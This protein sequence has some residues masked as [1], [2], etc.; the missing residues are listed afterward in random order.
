[1]NELN[2]W[3]NAGLTP[4]RTTKATAK[5]AQGIVENVRLTGM[6]LEGEAALWGRGM[7]L[8]TDIDNYRQL[9]AQGNP[10]LNAVL[11]R[12]ELGFA[13]SA[14]KTIRNRNSPFGA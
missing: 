5:T 1:M 4:R 7:E 11:I 8:I 3:G 9:L 10:E 2:K 14:E 12:F 13:A 6:E